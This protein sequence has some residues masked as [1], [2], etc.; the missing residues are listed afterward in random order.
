MT[1]VTKLIPDTSRAAQFALLIAISGLTGKIRICGYYRQNGI[2]Y[3][4]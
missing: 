4:V 2:N 1:T 3:H